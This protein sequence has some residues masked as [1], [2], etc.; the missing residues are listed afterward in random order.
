M[1]P[2]RTNNRSY[3]SARRLTPYMA[4]NS[5]LSLILLPRLIGSVLLKAISSL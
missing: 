2:L 4:L 3:L 1:L 5:I